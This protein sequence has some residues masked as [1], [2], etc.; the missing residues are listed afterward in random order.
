MEVYSMIIPKGYRLTVN[1]WHD[2]GSVSVYVD[3]NGL[4]TRATKE[5]GTL[6]AAVYKASKYG[7]YDN[8][9]PCSRTELRKYG[10]IF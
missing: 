10:I 6:P 8:I 7:G 3:E 4:I 1:K 2:F 9:M 5:N